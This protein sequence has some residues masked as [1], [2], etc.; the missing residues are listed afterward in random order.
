MSQKKLTIGLIGGGTV[1]NSVLELLEQT[2]SKLKS[3]HGLVFYIKR[4][5]EKD[6]KRRMTLKRFGGILCKNAKQIL[7]DTEIDTVIE[8]IGGKVDAEKIIIEALKKRKNVV[9]GNKG[10]L[11]SHGKRLFKEASKY[12]CYLGFRAALTGCQEI[13]NLLEYGVTSKTVLGIFNGTTNYIL[14]KMDENSMSFSDALKEAQKLGYAEKD[15]SLDIDGGDSANKLILTV[16]LAFA[17][18]LKLEDFHFEGIRDVEIQ[19]VQFAKELGYTIKLLGVMKKENNIL[20]V[21][22]H[23]CLIPEDTLLASVKG[24][25]NGIRVISDAGEVNDWTAEGAGGRAAAGAIIRDLI[26]IAN[27]TKFRLPELGGKLCI[28]KMSSVKCKYYIRLSAVNKPGVLAKIASVLAKHNINIRSV[29]QKGEE[30]ETIVPIIVIT[31]EAMEKEAQ[32]AI[33]MID[34]LPIVKRRTKLIRIEECVS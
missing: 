8:V 34:S 11:A 32:K 24:V 1:G 23:P 28:K 31:D 33:K 19:D 22:V 26:D 13:R 2:G 16:R 20:E 29:I 18:N 12:N 4:I 15:P 9:T 17:H 10:L 3:R 27:E 6:A 25:Y 7:D 21:R 5:A 14:S 30:I